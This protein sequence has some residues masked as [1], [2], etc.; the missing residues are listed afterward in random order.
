MKD[1]VSK[2]NTQLSQKEVIQPKRKKY[3]QIEQQP[4]IGHHSLT[5]PRYWDTVF[6]VLLGFETRTKLLTKLPSVKS[7]ATRE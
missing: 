5:V 3:N 6:K 4:F 1:T 2:E 7:Y